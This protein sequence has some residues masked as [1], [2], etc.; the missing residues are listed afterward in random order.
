[1]G[2]GV[3]VEEAGFVV[4]VDGAV[5]VDLVAGVGLVGFVTVALSSSESS[6]ESSS[7]EESSSSSSSSSSD[8]SSSSSESSSQATSSSAAGVD[9]VC[10]GQLYHD[11]SE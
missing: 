10:T 2:L 11:F 9:A 1:V 4:A 6:S 3:L 8:S 5:V 7:S